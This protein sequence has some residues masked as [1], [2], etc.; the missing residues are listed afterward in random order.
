MWVRIRRINAGIRL[1]ADTARRVAEESASCE[2]APN[3]SNHDL[4]ELQ[5]SFNDLGTLLAVENNATEQEKASHAALRDQMRQF[6]KL[7]D[8]VTDA[9]AKEQIA[10]NTVRA[11][12]DTYGFLHV[13]LWL[14]YRYVGEAADDGRGS[15]ESSAR[16]PETQADQILNKV[17]L[18]KAAEYR[19]RAQAGSSRATFDPSVRGVLDVAM[20]SQILSCPRLKDSPLFD[21]SKSKLRRQGYHSYLAL[22]LHVRGKMC[23]VL[24][25]FDSDPIPELNQKFLETFTDRLGLLVILAHM[26]QQMA[27]DRE[28]AEI[29]NLELEMANRSLER[30]NVQLAEADRIKGEFLANTSHE[31]RTPLNSILGFAKLILSRSYESEAELFENVKTI[32]ESGDR[33]LAMI[34]EVL[35]LAKIEAG[36]VSTKFAPV[37]V[38]TLIDT[39]RSL[40]SIQIETKGLTLVVEGIEPSPPLVRA[41][42]EKLYQVLVNLVGNAIKFTH[43]GSVTIAIRPDQTLGFLTIQVSDTGIGVTPE[44]QKK[45][46]QSFVQGDG[47]STRKYEGTGL[48]LAISRKLIE[49][50]GGTISLKSAGEGKGTTVTMLVPLWSGDQEAQENEAP[51]ARVLPVS[52]ESRTVVVIEDYL[53]LR[54]QL[55][56]LLIDDGYTVLTAR[57]AKQGMDLI[58]QHRPDAIVLDIHL[59]VEDEDSSVRSGYDIIRVLGKDTQMT[60]VPVLV[61]TGMPKEASLQLLGQTVLM[62]V[63][64]YGK[65][66]ENNVLLESLERLIA[67]RPQETDARGLEAEPEENRQAS[68]SQ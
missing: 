19:K 66:V 12:V 48:G 23:G 13:R 62:P 16:T 14:L 60:S 67:A 28:S 42:Q 18:L 65:P 30:T 57:T 50:I 36:K 56:E 44:I 33:L 20:S 1:A 9:G 5:Q 38:R 35:D 68:Q 47:S 53:E 40:M 15:P 64:V 25:F 41:D 63:E 26:N 58:Q 17:G 49:R 55:E 29:K 61:V 43:E 54:V 7:C 34:N 22:P 52:V 21:S 51:T 31:L 27:R 39:V 11:L 32:Q 59:P 37:D 10:E 8:N 6:L 4:A 3:F 2:I 46:F 24:E 45:L